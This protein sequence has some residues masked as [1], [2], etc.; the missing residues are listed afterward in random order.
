MAAGKCLDRALLG[1]LL[2]ALRGAYDYIVIDAA[3]AQDGAD[4]NVASECADAVVLAT[5]AGK[6]TKAELRRTM[7]QLHPANI[8]GAVLLD[9]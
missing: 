3:S 2:H 9:S 1:S 4:A 6:S 7:E 5:R 8:V